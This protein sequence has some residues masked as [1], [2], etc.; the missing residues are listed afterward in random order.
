MYY[1]RTG[2]HLINQGNMKGRDYL[3]KCL[4]RIKN[5]QENGENGQQKMAI[6]HI[7]IIMMEILFSVK[8]TLN[9]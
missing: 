2:F 3:K 6:L 1:I 5:L 9:Q 4:I 7:G 8:D